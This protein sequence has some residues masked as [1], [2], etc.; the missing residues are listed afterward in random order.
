[1]EIIIKPDYGEICREAAGIIQRAWKKKK[2]LVLGFPT[3][4]TPLGLYEK[5]IEL[6]D[7]GEMD[8]SDIVTF[9]VDEYLGLEETHPQS[10]ACYMENHLFRHVNIKKENIHHLSGKPDDIEEH[11]RA[12][13]MKIRRAGGINIQVLGIGTNGHIA[14]NEPSSSLSSRTRLEAL[15]QES[16]KANAHF[17]QDEKE[18]PRFCLTMGIGT[19]LE[20]RM[21]LLLASGRDKAEAV[22]GAIEGPITASVPA[23]ALQLH[24]QARFVIDEDAASKLIRKDYYRWKYE[25]R[26]KASEFLKK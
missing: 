21:I 15:A 19:F 22:A 18:V 17:F 25:N 7:N 20:S 13:E 23:S 6:Y 12:Y 1:M 14:F 10:F 11:C 16:I 9:N 5:L 26:V 8:F 4:R 3:G 24:P 2:S